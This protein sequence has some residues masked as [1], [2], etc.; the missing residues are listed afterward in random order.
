MQWPNQRVLYVRPEQILAGLVYPKS[1][2]VVY[3][4]G[5]N[6]PLPAGGYVNVPHQEIDL[7]SYLPVSGAVWAVIAMEIDGTVSVTTGG[8][9]ASW[10]ELNRADIPFV[11]GYAVAAIRLYNGQTNIQHGKFGSMIEDLRWFRSGE[12]GPYQP[13]DA[14]LTTIAALSPANDAVIQR[15]AEAGTSRTMAQLAA[16]LKSSLNY[17]DILGGH[18]AGGSIGAAS[19]AYIAPFI[20]GLDTVGRSTPWPGNGTI[21]HLTLRLPNSQPSTGSLVVEVYEGDAAGNLIATGVKITVA[22][23]G[24][25]GTYTNSVN[26][27]THTSGRL[28]HA[29]ITNNATSPVVIGGVTWEIEK[30]LR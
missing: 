23:G 16:D 13:L 14:D 4:C 18:G 25:A 19:I 8:A 2:L 11:N 20:A 27:A 5:R 22:A 26:T 7:T 17:A 9:A 29:R 24:A 12:G 30:E 1:G 6:V 15:K 3:V 21:K 28:V 10:S